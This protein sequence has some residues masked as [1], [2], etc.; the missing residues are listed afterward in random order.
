MEYRPPKSPWELYLGFLTIGMQFRNRFD[1]L[2]GILVLG[3]RGGALPLLHVTP[4][5]GRRMDGAALVRG[6]PELLSSR[7]R[8]G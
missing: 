4:A 1:L 3:L 5:G 8:I 6:R 2:D 7:A